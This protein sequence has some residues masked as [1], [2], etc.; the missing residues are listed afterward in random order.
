MKVKRLLAIGTLLAAVIG[1]ATAP[2]RATPTAMHRPVA[3]RHR[4]M[5]NYVMVT[6]HRMTTRPQAP[7]CH[8]WPFGPGDVRTASSVP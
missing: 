7:A 6:C 1:A 5:R 2:A 8:R 4:M 3:T